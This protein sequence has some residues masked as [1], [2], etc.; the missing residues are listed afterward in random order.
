MS[1]ILPGILETDWRK[2]EEKLTLISTFT[3]TAHID[4]LDGT[5][6]ENTSF[7]DPKPFAAFTNTLKLEL[8]LMVEDPLRYVEPFAA[9]GFQR[10]LGHIEKMPDQAAFL[11]EAEQY[12]E[13]GLVLDAHTPRTH[14]TVP[15]LD[16]DELL[17]MTVKAGFSGQAFLPGSLTKVAAVAK[18]HPLLMLGVDGGVTAETLKEA[19][20]AGA[21]RFVVTS[22]LFS[23]SDPKAAFQRLSETFATAEEAAVLSAEN[24]NK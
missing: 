17:V 24:E 12:G 10:F 19:Y 5:F 14:L 3:D 22:A 16:L 15:L 9:V 23:T 11:A 2:I 8:H 21:R 20:Q 6:A 7:H 1:A 13:V 4:L 18:D